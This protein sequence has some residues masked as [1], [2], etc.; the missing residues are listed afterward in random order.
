MELARGDGALRRADVVTGHP[1]S[2]GAVAYVERRE[3][4]VV[5]RVL[6]VIRRA[7]RLVHHVD[8]AAEV[9]NVLDAVAVLYRDGRPPDPRLRVAA[10]AMR[11]HQIASVADAAFDRS[12]TRAIGQPGVHLTDV[13]VHRLP[14]GHTRIVIWRRFQHT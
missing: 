9:L 2:G 12:A 13:I 5:R 4:G 11:A 1:R 8:Q 7:H 6:Q 3:A 10:H 14:Y